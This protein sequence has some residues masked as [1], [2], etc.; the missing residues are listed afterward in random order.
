M[1]AY[2]TQVFTSTASVAIA[3]GGLA[4]TNVGFAAVQDGVN[5]AQASFSGLDLTDWCR[6]LTFATWPTWLWTYTIT[7]IGCV[8]NGQC[9]ID[10]ACRITHCQ[11]HDGTGLVGNDVAAA[12]PFE[13]SFKEFEIGG[14]TEMWGFTS[15]QLKTFTGKKFQGFAFQVEEETGKPANVDIDGMTMIVYYDVRI[16]SLGALGTGI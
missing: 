13:T 3:G 5:F 14:D 10:T 9:D 16:R 4:W 1:G 8:V 6:A 11:L 15:D 2:S 12:K 7:G